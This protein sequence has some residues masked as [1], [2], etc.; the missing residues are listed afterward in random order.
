MQN[1]TPLGT[2]LHLEEL[3]RQAA[4]KSRSLRPKNQ[5]AWRAAA[6]SLTVVAHVRHL[7]GVGGRWREK[8][9][10]VVGA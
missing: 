5:S 9:S 6:L 2:A 3:D 10:R 7:L 1:D 4:P 8:A